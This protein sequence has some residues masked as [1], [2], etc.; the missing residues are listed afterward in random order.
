M[1]LGALCG[2][3]EGRWRYIID[4]FL[5]VLKRLREII[6]PLLECRGGPAGRH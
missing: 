5:L 3:G 4:T 6:V 1:G 2:L